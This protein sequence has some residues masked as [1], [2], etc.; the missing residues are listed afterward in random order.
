MTDS[1]AKKSFQLDLFSNPL[2]EVRDLTAIRGAIKPAGGI[3]YSVEDRRPRVYPGES[4]SF[5][6]VLMPFQVVRPPLMGNGYAPSAPVPHF[7]QVPLKI[8]S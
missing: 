4:I 7:T 3:I 1:M 5:S 2:Q 8:G 6:I